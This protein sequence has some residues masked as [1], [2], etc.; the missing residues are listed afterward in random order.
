[1]R[2]LVPFILIA[3][4]AGSQG[5][6]DEYPRCL[7]AGVLNQILELLVDRACEHPIIEK[8]FDPY[9]A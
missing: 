1:M 4:L 6:L 2:V 7:K 5:L 9:L 3:S 8:L